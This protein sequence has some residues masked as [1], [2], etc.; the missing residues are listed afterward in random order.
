MHNYLLAALWASISYILYTLIVKFVKDRRYARKAAKLGCKPPPLLPNNI[1]LGID[2][3]RESLKA[4]SAMLFPEFMTARCAQMGETHAYKIL[5]N[6]GFMTIDPKNIQAVLA[7]QFHDFE[8]GNQRRDNF[9]PLLG[10]G[11]FTSDGKSWEH[12]RAMM[13]PQFAREQVSDLKLEE[14][15]VQNMMRALRTGADGWTAD[16]DIQVLFFRLTLDSA[17]EFLFGESV[18][19]QIANL[20]IN[21]S[22]PS[23]R[24]AAK[25][26][27]VFAK[28]FDVSQ[29]YLATRA[30][31]MDKHWLVNNTEF[32]S[33]CK[34]THAF[35]DY[36]VKLALNKDFKEKELEKGNVSV[37]KDRYVF[38]DALAAQTHD[39]I[40]LRSQL[41]NILL[42]GR[43]TT[44]SLLGWL[45]FILARHPN[46]YAKLRAAILEAFGPYSAAP[47]DV[48]TY[49]SLKNC[50]YLQHCLNEAL[51]LYAVVPFNSRRA[52]RDTTIPRGGGPDGQSKIFVRKGE[53]VDYSVHIMHRRK[54][55]WG[56]DADEFRPE[57]WVGRKPGW[58]YLP[59]NGGPRICLGRECSLSLP[60]DIPSFLPPY[61]CLCPLLHL[62]ARSFREP[63]FVWYCGWWGGVAVEVRDRFGCQSIRLLDELPSTDAFL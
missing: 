5:G 19:S 16:I 53:Q 44:A 31:L 35:V 20:P 58:E 7:T 32:R 34:D 18:D 37:G 48:I 22:A 41:L 62:S 29:R 38:L 10:N 3:I 9:L 54:D 36:F 30:R 63:T 28:A 26:E 33:A 50:Q 25:D 49:T 51:R 14:E 46:H 60:L 2:R 40:E 23:E 45:F 6:M 12:S 57:R 8:I 61:T 4:D 56:E 11:I 42:A 43:D 15:H 55:L 1:P 52:V 13:R 17:C 27:K 39:P 47:D 59:F 21:A 24:D